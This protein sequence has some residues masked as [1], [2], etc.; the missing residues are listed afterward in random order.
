MFIHEVWMIRTLCRPHK[1]SPHDRLAINVRNQYWSHVQ[2]DVPGMK[3]VDDWQEATTN[4]PPLSLCSKAKIL[5]PVWKGKKEKRK[6]GFF[7][8]F[9][10][11]GASAWIVLTRRNKN[12]RG[13]KRATTDNVGLTK[14]NAEGKGW[15][16]WRNVEKGSEGACSLWPD[17]Q[18]CASLNKRPRMEEEAASA[19]QELVCHTLAFR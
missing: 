3:Q 4:L 16:G 13:R 15:W 9:N 17:T 7:F 8:P 10:C 18:N 11:H 2:S 14:S 1:K 5:I 19:K 6:E 12:D